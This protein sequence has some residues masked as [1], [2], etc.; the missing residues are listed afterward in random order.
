M[1]D[2][3]SRSARTSNALRAGLGCGLIRLGASNILRRSCI[4]AL[5]AALTTDIEV[6]I[7]KTWAEKLAEERDKPLH[8]PER[9]VLLENMAKLQAENGGKDCLCDE[10]GPCMYHACTSTIR[11]K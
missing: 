4:G 1:G 6:Y 11:H 7:M 9:I 10:E 8:N 2:S 5:R 3:S